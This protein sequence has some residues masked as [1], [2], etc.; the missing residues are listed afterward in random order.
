QA[1]SKASTRRAFREAARYLELA[2]QVVERR[3]DRDDIAEQ[4]ID[5]RLNLRDA[6][7]PAYSISRMA[8]VLQGAIRLAE[9]I[10]DRKSLGWAHTYQAFVAIERCDV[11]RALQ[12]GRRALALAEQIGNPVLTLSA[13]SMLLSIFYTLGDYR[14][15]IEIGRA[16]LEASDEVVVNGLS[17]GA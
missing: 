12:S 8:E 4:E 17:Q 6:L 16:C 15:A 3:S 5:I 2:L 11:P 10:G 1:A 7:H 14:Q 13:R 9:R